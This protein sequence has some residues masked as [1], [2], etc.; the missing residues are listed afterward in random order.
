M[1]HVW[2]EIKTN[3]HALSSFSMATKGDTPKKPANVQRAISSVNDNCRL[4]CCPLKIKYGE[5]KKNSYISTQN[6]FKVSKREGCILG[7]TLAELCSHI[8]LEIEKS[9]TFSDRV[10]HACGRK[11]RNAF[12]F[13]TFITSNLKREKDNSAVMEVD[14]HSGRFKRLLPTTISSPDRS[15]QAR[16]GKK[17]TG[18]K[19]SA[20][21]SLSFKD[22]SSSVVNTDSDHNELSTL[23]TADDSPREAGELF[24]S[25][26]NVED[27][28]ES[29]STEAK[30]VIVNPGGRVETFSSFHDKTKSIIVNLCR[31][32]ME[33]GWEF[34]ILCV[35]RRP[36]SPTRLDVEHCLLF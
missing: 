23:N 5:L 1:W 26:L 30:V 18:Q 13:H 29:S 2:Q 21:K 7:L 36:Q 10:C 31:K 8:G 12:D 33:N 27:L 20:K 9:D 25:Y 14:D 34:D 15:P 11:I 35:I 28:L 32:K 4:C 19:S 22:V 3:P 24:L 17:S 6:L 16:K